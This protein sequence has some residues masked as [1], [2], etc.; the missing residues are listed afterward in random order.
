MQFN[1][2]M[3]NQLKIAEKDDLPAEFQ[4]HMRRDGVL[5]RVAAPKWVKRTVFFRDRGMCVFCH[6]DLSGLVSSMPESNFDHIVALKNGGMNDVTNIQLMC[7][8]CNRIKSA[9]SGRTSDEYEQW[10]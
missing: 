10:Y 7:G 4:I 3:A 2:L 5:R 1:Q 9:G 6:N 8:K